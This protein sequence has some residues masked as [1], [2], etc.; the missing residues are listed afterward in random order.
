MKALAERDEACLLK[1]EHRLERDVYPFHQDLTAEQATSPELVL[2][3]NEED[4]AVQDLVRLHYVAMMVPD[5]WDHHNS[6]LLHIRWYPFDFR[7][8]HPGRC[9]RVKMT[10]HY[11]VDHLSLI[12]RPVD[13]KLIARGKT[14]LGVGPSTFAKHQQGWGHH[15]KQM[16]NE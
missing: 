1:A 16:V 10:V 12:G 9:A 5:E 6:I 7:F 11:E 15:D 3:G 2:E 13:P 14:N 8:L 4:R